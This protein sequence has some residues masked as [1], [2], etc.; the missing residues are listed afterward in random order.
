MCSKVFMVCG[1]FNTNHSVDS[2]D[3]GVHSSHTL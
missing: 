3:T 1:E 2:A